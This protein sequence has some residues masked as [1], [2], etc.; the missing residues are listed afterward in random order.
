MNKPQPQ[1]DLVELTI[2]RYD[3]Y[4]KM[5]DVENTKI[6]DQDIS[7]EIDNLD[8]GIDSAVLRIKA[9]RE[10]KGGRLWAG[11]PLTTD[12]GIAL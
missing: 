8:D 6:E 5:G 11:G 4:V 9:E 12:Q 7:D 2:S 1:N 3:L 10:S